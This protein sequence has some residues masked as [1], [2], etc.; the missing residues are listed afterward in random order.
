M[1]RRQPQPLRS[2]PTWTNG[3][4]EPSELDTRLAVHASTEGGEPIDVAFARLRGGR[5]PAL[6]RP[7]D[8]AIVEVPHGIGLRALREIQVVG[9]PVEGYREPP[10]V[11]PLELLGRTRL[12]GGGTGSEL[13]TVRWSATL[14]PHQPESFFAEGAARIG[15]NLD[16]AKVD[17]AAL[18]FLEALRTAPRPWS[19]FAVLVLVLGLASREPGHNALAVDLTIAELDAHRLDTRALIAPLARLHAARFLKTPRWTRAL[20]QVAAA[21][22]NCRSEVLVVLQS[23][24]RGDPKNAP[25][26]DKALVDLLLELLADAGATLTDEAART[27]LA[28]SRHASRLRAH[29]P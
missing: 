10:A 15:N 11:D 22:P 29:L 12:T 18:A 7:T 3:A 21:S 4:I 16:W 17:W 28:A 20:G 25:R 9:V 23:V 27:Y 5:T 2:L 26:D 19:P 6:V 14:I 13:G 24:L 8:F 1:Q